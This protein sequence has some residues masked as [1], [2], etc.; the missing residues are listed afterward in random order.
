MSRIE[1]NVVWADGKVCLVRQGL[2]AR[3]IREGQKLIEEMR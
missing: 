1:T 2:T 3:E